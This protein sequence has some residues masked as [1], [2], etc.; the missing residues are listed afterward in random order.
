M[1]TG[2]SRGQEGKA[3]EAVGVAPRR[4]RGLEEARHAVAQ[5]GAAILG[6]IGSERVAV[7]ILGAFLAEQAVRVDTQFE[8]TGGEIADVP[9]A[10]DGRGPTVPLAAAKQLRPHND[11]FDFGDHAPDYVALWCDRPCTTGG[12]SFAVDQVRLMDALAAD[13]ATAD[14]AEF[15]RTVDIDPARPAAPR[16]VPGPV[17]DTRAGDGT[18]WRVR[19]HSGL[20]ALPGPD[21]AAHREMIGRWRDAVHAANAAGPRFRLGAGDLLLLDNYRVSH[22]RDPY[23]DPSRRV[24]SIWAWS[25]GAVRVPNGP[26]SVATPDTAALGS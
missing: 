14:L 11:G 21:E 1:P 9:V 18:R 26:L 12:A 24:V 23:D 4:A 13:P 25:A 8:A 19:V 10:A 2:L 5:D 20:S 15:C 17:A 6:G 3:M 16:G 7:A 22:G